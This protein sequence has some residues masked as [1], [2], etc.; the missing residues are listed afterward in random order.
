[1]FLCHDRIVP[2]RN[3]DWLRKEILCRDRACVVMTERAV[4]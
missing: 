1:M 2:H 4:G 3:K